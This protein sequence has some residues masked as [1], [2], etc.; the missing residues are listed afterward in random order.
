MDGMSGLSKKETC[1]R[2]RMAVWPF[3]RNY[4]PFYK[5]FYKYYNVIILILL[6]I[7][8]NFQGNIFEILYFFDLWLLLGGVYRGS[9]SIRGQ[10]RGSLLF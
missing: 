5:P 1:L 10:V 3:S 8:A 2:G 6:L 7:V 4:E 9:T